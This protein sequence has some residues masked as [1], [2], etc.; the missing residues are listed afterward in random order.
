MRL[1]SYL[2]YYTWYENLPDSDVFKSVLLFQL[3]DA[4]NLAAIYIFHVTYAYWGLLSLY[5]IMRS[6]DCGY[7]YIYSSRDIECVIRKYSLTK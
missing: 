7:W 6:G 4:S 3:M 5:R 2:G 1:V